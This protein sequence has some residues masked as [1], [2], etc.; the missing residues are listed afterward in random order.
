MALAPAVKS[1]RT[2]SGRRRAA[3]RDPARAGAAAARD[4]RAPARGARVGALHPRPR[5]RGVRGGVRRLRRPPTLHRRRQRHRG[6]DDR[7]A[8]AR[9]PARGRGG[10]PGVSFF[11]TAEAVVNAGARARVRRHR[12][13]DALHD[14]GDRRARAHRPHAGDVPVHLFGNPAPMAGADGPGAHARPRGARGRRPGRGG[15]LRGQ[16]RRRA[17]RRRLVQLLPRK[18]PRRHRRRGG[19][20]HRRRR[21]RPHGADASRPRP[22]RSVGPRRGRLQLAPRRAPGGGAARPAAPSSRGGRRRGARRLAPTSGRGSA[23]WSRS[24]GKPR[25]ARARITCTSSAPRPA[26]RSARR[27]GGR[28]RDEGLLHDAAEPPAGARRRRARAARLPNSERLASQGLAL[29]MG[30]ALDEPTVGLVVDA[31]RALV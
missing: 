13:R 28:C 10:R 5:G 31:I 20:P 4:R 14:R 18:E 25:A 3:V 1:G 11:A 6:A 21:G 15:E 2:P 19:D 9:H 24:S 12:R 30:Q 16:A 26:T 27:C 17:R 23:T 8:R 7:A 22:G 29:P